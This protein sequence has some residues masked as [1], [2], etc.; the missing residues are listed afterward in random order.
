MYPL[1][2]QEVRR[3]R[4]GR[5][6]TTGSIIH[7]FTMKKRA[8]LALRR[9]R[10]TCTTED[11]HCVVYGDST[12]DDVDWQQHVST[13]K[14]RSA[15]YGNISEVI[16]QKSNSYTP[17]ATHRTSD[18]QKQRAVECNVNH[19]R[20]GQYLYPALAWRCPPSSPRHAWP[21]TT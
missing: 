21:R 10:V 2:N 12:H 15:E 11:K 16:S 5:E 13:V 7:L 8:K 1:S 17:Q 14:P 3:K 4:A 9:L 18:C 19:R 20:G 6:S